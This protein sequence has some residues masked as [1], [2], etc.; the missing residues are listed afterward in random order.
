MWIIFSYKC[1]TPSK[2][3]K[4]PS[5]KEFQV[6]TCMLTTYNKAKQHKN[7]AIIPHPSQS[8]EFFVA[9][10]QKQLWKPRAQ[11]VIGLGIF[12]ASLIQQFFERAYLP[13]AGDLTSTTTSQNRSIKAFRGAYF[14]LHLAPLPAR[15]WCNSDEF[16]RG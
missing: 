15:P 14:S 9:F 8:H 11:H 16:M 5:L 3:S 4:I 7:Y 10:Y 13:L 12:L 6:G 2:E 1:T